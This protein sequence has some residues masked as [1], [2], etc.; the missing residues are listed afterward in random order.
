MEQRDSSKT[1]ILTIIGIS[2]LVFSI[3]GLSFAT[4]I[5]TQKGTKDN[6]ISTG[7]VYMTYS[8]DTNGIKIENA[9]PTTDVAGKVLNGKNEYFDFTVSSKLSAK[10]SIMYEVAATK[11][12][13]STIADKDVKIYLEKQKSGT[14]TEVF[15][16][17][18]YVPLKKKTD[19]GTPVGSMVLTKITHNKS[20]TDNYRLR[21]WLADTAIVDG[22][23]KFYTVKVDVHA[24]V[25]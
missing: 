6:T 24:K 22:T 21:M 17:S 11:D 23:S 20:Q 2:I 19:L 13:N 4:F 9:L 10:V 12:K 16:P 14:Y 7:T 15:A 8:E 18:A 5:G 3:V 1:I 25:D